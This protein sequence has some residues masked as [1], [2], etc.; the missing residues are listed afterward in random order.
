MAMKPMRRPVLHLL[1]RLAGLTGAVIAIGGLFVW[2]VLRSDSVGIILTIA[3]AVIAAAALFYDFSGL[4]GGISARRGA[5]GLNVFLQIAMAIA[6]IVMLNV[7]SF[8]HFHRYDWTR[9]HRFTLPDDVRQ[10]LAK[11]TDTTEIVVLQR[12]VSFGQG[13]DNKQDKYDLAA[14]RKIIEKV[15]DLA[16]Q[17][18]DLGP[19]FRVQ[20]LDIQD[21]DYLDKLRQLPKE[22]AAAV[23]KAPENS[24]FFYAHYKNDKNQKG[25]ERTLIQRLSFSDVYQLDKEA[26]MKADDPRMIALAGAKAISLA[27]MPLTS[28]PSLAANACYPERT[29][30]RGNLVLKYQGIASIARKILNIEEKKYRVASLIFHPALGFSNRDFP[31]Y[32][33]TGAKKVLGEQGML[34]TDIV[35]HKLTPRGQPMMDTASA[36]TYEES[37][38]KQ[39]QDLLVLIE[40]SRAKLT[41]ERKE[42]LELYNLW[43]KS[44]LPEL[45]KKYAYFILPNGQEGVRERTWIAKFRKERIDFKVID[46]DEDDVNNYTALYKHQLDLRDALLESNESRQQKLLDE[47]SH[48]HAESLAE[49]ERNQDVEAKMKDILSNIDL[50][51]VPRLTLTNAAHEDALN[52]PNRAHALSAEQLKAVKAFM[53]EGKPVL[54]LL[55]PAN[56]PSEQ[57]RQPKAKRDP[58]EIDPL[59]TALTELGFKLPRQTILYDLEGDEYQERKVG[60]LSREKD[61][62]VPGLLFDVGTKIGLIRKPRGSHHVFRATPQ[63]AA[64]VVGGLALPLFSAWF[65]VPAMTLGSAPSAADGMKYPLKPSRIRTSLYV[66]GR[67]AVNRDSFE[68]R[69]RNPRPVYYYDIA[70]DQAARVVGSLALANLACRF[71]AAAISMNPVLDENGV[72][73]LTQNDCWNEDNPFTSEKGDV[74]RYLPPKDD[75]PRQGTIEEVRRGPFPVGVAAEVTIPES[76]YEHSYDKPKKERIVVIGSGGVFMGPTLPPL[77]QKMLLD[78][79]NWLLQR[80]TLL[81]RNDETWQYPRLYPTREQQALWEWGARFG[82]PLCFIILGMGV[83]LV[84]RMR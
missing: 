69:I 27:A 18:Q 65:Q 37:R 13:A 54:F 32:S 58:V 7:F 35:L 42:L 78:V 79:V 71:G 61:V 28:G 2:L 33:M 75:D 9:D 72:F 60:I 48:L 62:E 17:F 38:Y 26:S 34:T 46:V 23:D 14:Q 45:N 84:R 80:D 73:L 56:E 57:P 39:I 59:E 3:G 70:P 64:G 40:N 68:V 83:F 6:V 53:S 19:R 36:L 50:L 11:L 81:A 15:K 77:K 22:L 82:L 52:L 29:E 25:K 43:S 16:E 41:S 31:D 4:S 21:D 66:T 51:I 8:Q 30:P 74:P 10:E 76:W 20:V 1:V 47:K 12:Y 63:K 44:T 67:T 55:G 49:K 5:F 24:I